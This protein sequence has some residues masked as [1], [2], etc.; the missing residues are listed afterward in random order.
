M[1]GISMRM[2][3]SLLLLLAALAVIGCAHTA[4]TIREDHSAASSAPVVTPRPAII[5]A[6]G[7]SDCRF[8]AVTIKFDT[9]GTF[10]YW[11]H[12]DIKIDDEP[13]DSITGTWRWSGSVLELTASYHLYDVR[14]HP[15]SY[16][17]EVCLLPEHARQWQA[18]DGTE[19]PD[20][21]LFRIRD[22]DERQ[23]FARRRRGV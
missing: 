3:R 2:K 23:P 6:W 1:F 13:D 5:G 21:L 19:Y 22:F 18:D 10:H 7:T 14:F 15:Y 9:N 16:K 11:F 20:R 17:G 12:T 8:E 4:P